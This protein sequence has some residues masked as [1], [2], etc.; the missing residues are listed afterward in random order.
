MEFYGVYNI[1]NEKGRNFE[2]IL[3][4]VCNEGIWWFME[5]YS[6][7]FWIYFGNRKVIIEFD[8][9]WV[10]EVFDCVKI[11]VLLVFVW[12]IFWSVEVIGNGELFCG[13]FGV[14]RCKL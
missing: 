10:M 14:D 7:G 2:C 5:N 8:W 12:S 1:N 13:D 11:G 4:L 3:F 9:I 6:G